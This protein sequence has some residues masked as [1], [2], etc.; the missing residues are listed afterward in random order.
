MRHKSIVELLLLYPALRTQGISSAWKNTLHW[1]ALKLCCMNDHRRNGTF[2]GIDTANHFT[3][4]RIASTPTCVPAACLFHLCC[5]AYPI[6]FRDFLKQLEVK[7]LLFTPFSFAILSTKAL[8]CLRISRIQ[9]QQPAIQSFFLICQIWFW[10]DFGACAS[11]PL[12]L[13]LNII[14][15]M[16]WCEASARLSDVLCSAHACI[17]LAIN[18]W[19]AKAGC[20][21]MQSKVVRGGRRRD[22]HVLRIVLPETRH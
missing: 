2:N 9:P 10:T 14:F 13:Y 16:P 6:F 15:G 8:T 5:Q 12:T 18:L 11:R 19:I 7:S 21:C 4:S 1:S 17:W 20:S 3:V 22:Q